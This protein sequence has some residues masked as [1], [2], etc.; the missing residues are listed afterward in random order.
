MS[1]SVEQMSEVNDKQAGKIDKYYQDKID[2]MDHLKKTFEVFF[3]GRESQKN[4]E[5]NGIGGRPREN[6]GGSFSSSGN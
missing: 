5:D 6:R 4:V 2:S 1:E 3:S